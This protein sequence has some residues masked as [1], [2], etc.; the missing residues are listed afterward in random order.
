MIHAT[1]IP[2]PV[3]LTQQKAIESGGV[4]RS[5]GVVDLMSAIDMVAPSHGLQSRCRPH[6]GGS[7]LSEF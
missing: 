7:R 5:A 4:V 6:P 3:D 2:V 1:K